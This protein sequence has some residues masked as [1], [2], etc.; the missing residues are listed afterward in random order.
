MLPKKYAKVS[1]SAIFHDIIFYF[2]QKSSLTQVDI[3]HK[4]LNTTE[5]SG[6]AAGFFLATM[7]GM[8]GAR[9]AQFSFTLSQCSH[10]QRA[11]LSSTG[12][13]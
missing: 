7:Q 4:I 11:L 2:I 13:P 5:Q 10:P 12:Y 9:T 8:A 3:T 6:A 1:Q